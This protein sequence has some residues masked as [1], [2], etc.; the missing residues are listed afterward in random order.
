MS[1]KRMKNLRNH[2]LRDLGEDSSIYSYLK[3]LELD[4]VAEN[5]GS[6]KTDLSPLW[7]I[8]TDTQ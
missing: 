1:L 2:G 4:Q 7:W 3:R 5:V 6:I 8:E